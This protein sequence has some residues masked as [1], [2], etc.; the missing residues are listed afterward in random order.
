MSS[1][2]TFSGFNDIDFNL[3][4]NSIMQ[5]ASQPLTVLQRRQSA[6]QSQMETYDAFA[7]HAAT[8][9]TVA[10]A[11]GDLG[12]LALLAG[13]SSNDQAVSVS[14]GAAALPGEIDVVVTELAAAQVTASATTAADANTTV[15][16]SSGTL[17]IGGV[18]VAIA[19]DVTLQQLAAA[20]NG[21]D[22]IGVRAAVIGSTQSG[23]RLVLTASATG[24]ANAFTIANG[25]AGGAGI[26]FTDTNGDGVSGDSAADNA[27]SATDAALL[28]NNVAVTG[29]SNTFEDV[30][31]G[32]TITARRKDPATAVHVSVATDVTKL[33]EKVEAFIGAYNTLSKFVAEQRASAAKGEGDSLGREPILRQLYNSLRTELIAAQG[34][35]VFSRLSEIGI[36]F[37]TTGELA[38]DGAVFEDAIAV[39]GDDVKA[40]LGG[41]DGVFPEI[42]TLLDDYANADG[43]IPA[44]RDRLSRQIDGID[45]QIIAMQARLAQQRESLQR[46]FVEADLAI[47]RL[48]SQSNALGTFGGGLGSF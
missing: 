20:I 39:S 42:S 6:L 46:Q 37:T 33:R 22:G 19:G 29:S 5:Q 28:I 30:I 11:L 3:V 14:V 48:R 41:I 7:G 21:T 12:S 45:A 2:I 9:R 25:L 32:V 16:A 23:Y 8:L 36:A 35:G 40:L 44:G 4:L 47:S 24:V 31:T 43:L 38:L 26:S 13:T 10:D 34:S 17:T 1:P 18:A 27:V 15:V